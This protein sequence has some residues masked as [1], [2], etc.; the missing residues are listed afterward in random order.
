MRSWKYKGIGNLLAADWITATISWVIFFLYRKVKTLDMDVADV[1]PIIKASEWITILLVVPLGWLVLYMF[2]GTYTSLFRKSRLREFNRTLV[3]TIIGVVSLFFISVLNDEQHDYSYYYKAFITLFFLHFSITLIGRILVLNLAKRSL[4]NGKVGFNTLIIGGNKIAIDI[5]HEIIENRKT[6]GNRF[7][8]FVY[9]E[10][11]GTNGL[12]KY[13]TKLGSFDD[14]ESI[15][16]QYDIEEVIVAIETSEHHRLEELLPKLIHKEVIIKLRPDTFD[17]MTGFVKTSN[18]YGSFL[19]E[20]FPDLMEDWERVVKRALDIACSGLALIIMSPVYIFAAIKVRLSSEGPLIYKQQR[21]GR[22][23]T[24]FY[25]YKFRSMFVNAE[26]NGPALSSDND[27]RIT[28]WGRIMRKW[29]IDE[30][31]QMV[32]ILKGEMSLVGPRP[33]RQYFIDQICKTHPHYRLV[34]KVKPGLTSWGMVK[35]GYAE[36]VNEML[37]RMKYDL[38]YIEN[39]SLAL[40][41]RI[42]IHTVLVIL[43]GRGK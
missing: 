23:G 43:Q 31:P 3:S 26:H 22:Y 16:D 19:V 39:I 37:E 25:I 11:N 6:P 30:L 9:A 1:L 29:R 4:V 42:M 5:Y 36:N 7:Q 15:I 28:S 32:N 10:P 2:S 38:L 41:F 35:Y 24:P 40:D 8:G 17:I 21:I 34:H 13:L 12:S 20:I 33:E 14:I 18:V 27:P